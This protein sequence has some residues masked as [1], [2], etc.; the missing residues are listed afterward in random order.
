MIHA[1]CPRRVRTWW[2]FS[3]L[4][5]TLVFSTEWLPALV[6]HSDLLPPPPAVTGH[7]RA[8]ARGQRTPSVWCAGRRIAALGL[9]SPQAEAL[10]LPRVAAAAVPGVGRDALN[11]RL[12]DRRLPLSETAPP[13]WER[14]IQNAQASVYDSWR[15]ECSARGRPRPSYRWLKNGEPLRP[16]VSRGVDGGDSRTGGGTSSPGQGQPAVRG[17]EAGAGE[18]DSLCRC[19]SQPMGPLDEL[20]GAA[21][22]TPFSH[23]ENGGW[24]RQV[25]C[26]VPYCQWQI[27]IQTSLPS[28]TAPSVSL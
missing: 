23:G 12:A 14:R 25:T 1:L 26:R 4:T 18:C 2:A 22:T 15:W 5:Y 11:S 28:S 9:Q 3:D 8:A 6:P 27:R 17:C 13:E 10:A 16:Q 7:R 21:H 20:R 19:T 24:R